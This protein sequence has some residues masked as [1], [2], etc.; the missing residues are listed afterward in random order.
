MN[1]PNIL[2]IFRIILIPVFV[3]LFFSEMPNNLNYALLVFFI[4]GVTDVLDGFIARRFN[5]VTDVGK[6][7]DPLADKIMLLSVLICLASTDLVPIWILFIIML[8]ELFMIYGGIQLYFSKS[9]II[10]PSNKYGKIGT[11]SFYLAICL[12]LLE[13]DSL[14][15]RSILYLAVIIA[16][17]AFFNYV[18]IAV[19]AKKSIT[20]EN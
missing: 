7:L 19:G 9:K 11:V 4:A 10:I 14:L 12:V 17:V 2:T 8:K 1:I 6:V 20:S 13:L 15:T 3:M 5:M 18:R 16:M